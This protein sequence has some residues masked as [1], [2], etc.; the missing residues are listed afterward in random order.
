[1]SIA[2]QLMPV[3]PSWDPAFGRKEPPLVVL[4][5]RLITFAA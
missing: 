1:V 4:V 5:D 3:H 2:G